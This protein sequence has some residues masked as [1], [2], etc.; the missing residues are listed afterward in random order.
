MFIIEY[1][2][3]RRLHPHMQHA[4]ILDAVKA[5]WNIPVG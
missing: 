2:V 5:F 1:L 3:R 4:H